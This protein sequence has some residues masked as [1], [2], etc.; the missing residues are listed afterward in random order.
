MKASLACLTS[1]IGWL[2]FIAARGTIGGL[3]MDLGFGLYSVLKIQISI[4]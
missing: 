4:T 2:I 3:L 1:S